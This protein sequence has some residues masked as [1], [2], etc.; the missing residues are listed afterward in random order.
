MKNVVPA[1]MTA[2]CQGM[3]LT[4]TR[5]RQMGITVQYRKTSFTS[6]VMYGTF[7]S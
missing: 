4:L 3:S 5:G 6:A 7:S 2:S 1:G